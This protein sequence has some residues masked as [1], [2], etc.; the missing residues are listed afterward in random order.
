MMEEI[1][2]N[3]VECG[4]SFVILHLAAKFCSQQCK[5]RRHNRT[6][7]QARNERDRKIWGGMK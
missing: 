7:N 4:R 5:W 6:A 3:C 2:R 1:K